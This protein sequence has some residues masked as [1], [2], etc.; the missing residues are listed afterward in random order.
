MRPAAETLAAA[1]LAASRG[2]HRDQRNLRQ[3]AGAVARRGP[4]RACRYS[5]ADAG[6]ARLRIR[7]PAAS[8]DRSALC[9][10]MPKPAAVSAN[11]VSSDRRPQQVEKRYGQRHPAEDFVVEEDDRNP[12]RRA[13]PG[14]QTGLAGQLGVQILDRHVADIER[15][16]DRKKGDDQKPVGLSRCRQKQ[17]ALHRITQELRIGAAAKSITTDRRGGIECELD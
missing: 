17:W 9:R 14:L 13:Q 4:D 6:R 10:T 7:T 11:A 2:L 1:M 12:K 16:A 15:L 3:L 5:G 8:A